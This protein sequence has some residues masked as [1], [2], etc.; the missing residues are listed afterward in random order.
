[1]HP[2]LAL[3]RQPPGIER[4]AGRPASVDGTGSS[5]RPDSGWAA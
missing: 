4:R 2:A 5:E 1:M 3:L